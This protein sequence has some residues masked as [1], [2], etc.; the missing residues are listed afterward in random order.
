L[1]FRENEKWSESIEDDVMLRKIFKL[2]QE[3][4]N[5]QLDL[6]K[7]WEEDGRP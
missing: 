3:Q 2:A 4:T 1:G 5:I 7:E 6:I